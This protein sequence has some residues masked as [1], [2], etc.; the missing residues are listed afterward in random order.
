MTAHLY[1]RICAL[2]AE[3]R[4]L[5]SDNASLRKLNAELSSE[6]DGARGAR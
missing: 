5:K 3:L 6:L 1:A 2:T 4:S